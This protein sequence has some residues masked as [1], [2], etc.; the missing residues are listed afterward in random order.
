M[1]D[2]FRSAS[3]TELIPLKGVWGE[4]EL[5]SSL[6]TKLL[7]KAT[8]LPPQLP[9]LLPQGTVH[10]DTPTV[11]SHRAQ[12]HFFPSQKGARTH[13]TGRPEGPLR[14]YVQTAA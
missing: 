11:P 8:A 14:L 2:G 13:C 5:L 1:T 9:P 10:Q 3:V 7:Q 6:L 12:K 4:P